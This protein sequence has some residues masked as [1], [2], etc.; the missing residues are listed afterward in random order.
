MPRRE[1]ESF[2][3]RGT[4]FGICGQYLY[5]NGTCPNARDHVDDGD[6]PHEA[7]HNHE[8]C[9]ACQVES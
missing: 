6:V 7:E 1:C 8:A 3:R 9:P 2:A 5:A 4:G